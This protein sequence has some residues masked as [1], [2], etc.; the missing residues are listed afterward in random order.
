MG[1]REY[2]ESI[3]DKTWTFKVQVILIH[4]R[5]GIMGSGPLKT[6]K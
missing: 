6:L 3:C 2:P 1:K 4:V 5:E